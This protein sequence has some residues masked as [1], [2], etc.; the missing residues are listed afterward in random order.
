MVFLFGNAL[1]NIFKKK[2]YFLYKHDTKTK[3]KFKKL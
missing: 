2:I 3:K 1:I